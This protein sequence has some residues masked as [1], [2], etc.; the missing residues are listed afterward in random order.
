MCDQSPIDFYFYL[1]YA[2]PHISFYQKRTRIQTVTSIYIYINFISP[3]VDSPHIT[4]AGVIWLQ[5]LIGHLHLLGVWCGKD[6]RATT[7][8]TRVF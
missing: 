5:F 4:N 8:K 7:I 2:P 3:M 1:F 6:Q